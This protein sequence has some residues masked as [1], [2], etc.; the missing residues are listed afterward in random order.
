[1]GNSF[2]GSRLGSSFRC[3]VEVWFCGTGFYGYMVCGFL[4]KSSMT[5]TTATSTTTATTTA[6]TERLF[7]VLRVYWLVIHSTNRG[8]V[9]LWFCEGA[10]ELSTRKALRVNNVDC[11][12][13]FYQGR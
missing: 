10:E 3:S 4:G 1:M 6:T 2:Y 7:E 5:T 9:I 11:E 12:G 8:L 13:V